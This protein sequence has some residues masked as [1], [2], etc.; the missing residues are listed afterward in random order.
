MLAAISNDQYVYQMKLVEPPREKIETP[1]K[2]IAFII[3]IWIL[4]CMQ[5][6][7]ESSVLHVSIRL[8][9]KYGDNIGMS[10]A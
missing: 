7:T 1:A 4:L 3:Q 9:E 6:T 5:F 2:I 8:I 10:R